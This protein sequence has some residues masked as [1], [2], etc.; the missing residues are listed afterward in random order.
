MSQFQKQSYFKK[1]IY[2]PITL[3]ALGVVVLL[4]IYGVVD[5]IPKYRD[6][7]RAERAMENKKEVLIEREEKLTNELNKLQTP[8]GVEESIRENLNVVKEG[9]HVI[10]IVE[11]KAITSSGVEQTEKTFWQRLFE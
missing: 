3:V 8:E 4:A 2:S 9:E 1:I 6:A 5:I 7:I 11:P 10:M